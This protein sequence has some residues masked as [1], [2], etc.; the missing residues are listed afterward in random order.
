MADRSRSRSP[1]RGAPPADDQQPPS[2]APPADAPPADG[3][4]QGDM[5][6]EEVKLYVGNLDYGMLDFFRPDAFF[7]L[8]C[9][10]ASPDN[11]MLILSP[12]FLQPRTKLASARSSPSSEPS[13]KSFCRWNVVPHALV[14]L[15]L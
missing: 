6:G 2:D 12:F 1:D 8:R 4:A 15:G 3:G 10:I 7:F 13:R 9:H 14:G 11:A 5:N